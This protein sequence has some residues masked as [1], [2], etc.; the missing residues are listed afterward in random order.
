MCEMSVP[1]YVSVP[2][3]YVFKQL[4]L[5]LITIHIDY[6]PNTGYMVAYEAVLMK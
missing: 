1:P 2:P 3:Y 6:T 4:A 5:I